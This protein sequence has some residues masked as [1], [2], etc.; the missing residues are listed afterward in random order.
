M[1]DNSDR[2]SRW[3]GGDWWL[4]DLIMWGCA[5]AG[6]AGARYLAAMANVLDARLVT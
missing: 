5:V 2:E 3:S 6:P 1:D 4:A